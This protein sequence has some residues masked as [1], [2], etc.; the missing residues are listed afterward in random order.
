MGVQHC[1]RPSPTVVVSVGLTEQ[2]TEVPS[3]DH[4]ATNGIVTGYERSEIGRQEVK[5]RSSNRYLTFAL[6]S[7]VRHD[8]FH[9]SVMREEEMS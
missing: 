2:T 9:W 3:K 8:G 4:V 6:T 5:G 1:S 7:Q